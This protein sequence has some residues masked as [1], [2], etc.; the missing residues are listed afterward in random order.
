MFNIEKAVVGVSWR[1]FKSDD[2]KDK[3]LCDVSVK[4]QTAPATKKPDYLSIRLNF[5]NDIKADFA[6]ALRDAERLVGQQVR[7]YKVFDMSGFISVR[8]HKSKDGK[9]TLDPVFVVKKFVSH[10]DLKST[11]KHLKEADADLPF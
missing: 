3:I 1:H 2:G 9:E 7:F 11:I 10:E 5:T 8:R 6:V 4:G